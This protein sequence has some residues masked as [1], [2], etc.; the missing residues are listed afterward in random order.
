MIQSS[1]GSNDTSSDGECK[2]KSR[3]TSPP[4]KR[5]PD[6]FDSSD[7]SDVD[8]DT[9]PEQVLYNQ[10]EDYYNKQYKAYEVQTSDNFVNSKIWNIDYDRCK[11]LIYVFVA[12]VK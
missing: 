8:N 11:D 3:A 2:N 6:D 4:L 1:C 5:I 12:T 7:D 9:E 10:M